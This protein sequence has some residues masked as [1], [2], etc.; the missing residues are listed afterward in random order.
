MAPPYYSSPALAL[1]SLQGGRSWLH[2]VFIPQGKRQ[3][4]MVRSSTGDE[5]GKQI[6]AN[7][8]MS[9]VRKTAEADDALGFF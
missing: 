3:E 9:R 5:I 7:G 1:V 6:G 2:A 4:G 8:N